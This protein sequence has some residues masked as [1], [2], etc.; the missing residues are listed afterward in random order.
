VG[1]FWRDLGEFV[2]ILQKRYLPPREQQ[3]LTA[4]SYLSDADQMVRAVKESSFFGA[5]I[6][7]H[8]LTLRLDEI[9]RASRY[10]NA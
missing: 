4:I 5:A 1:I 6:S 3:E 8:T 7:D 9:A 2:S 10:Y